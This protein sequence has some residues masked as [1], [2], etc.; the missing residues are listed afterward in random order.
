MPSLAFPYKDPSTS[1]YLHDS[2][3]S[4]RTAKCPSACQ[5]LEPLYSHAQACCDA[6]NSWSLQRSSWVFGFYIGL[7]IQSS[8]LGTCT[9]HMV[10]QAMLYN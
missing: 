10:F 2:V 3:S 5:R 6:V 9:T 4:V 1:S 7:E 8:R